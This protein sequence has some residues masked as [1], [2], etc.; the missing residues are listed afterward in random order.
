M[1]NVHKITG[2]VGGVEF[3]LWRMSGTEELGQSFQYEIEMLSETGTVAAKDMLGKPLVVTINAEGFDSRQFH[4]LVSRFERRGYRKPFYAYRATIRPW[5]W[6]L[7]HTADCRIFQTKSI[8][9]I[10]TDVF[11]TKNGFSDFRFSLNET[12]K[13]REYCVQYRESDFHFVSRLMEEEGIYYFFEH[14]DSKHTLV[15]ADGTAAHAGVC[16]SGTPVRFDTSG[17]S[18]GENEHL[19]NWTPA[20][21]LW[22]TGYTVR[23]Y[24]FEK[25]SANLEAKSQI[26]QQHS[27][28]SYEWYDYPN[29]YKEVADGTRYAKVWVE[30]FQSRY[31]L[32]AGAGSSQR[33]ATGCKFTLSEHPDDAENAEYL[34]V[35]TNVTIQSGEIAAFAGDMSNKFD[36]KLTAIKATKQYRVPRQ[37]KKP[38]IAGPQTAIV[39]GKSG[40]EIWTDKY[41]RVKVQ[42]P[43]DRVGKKDETSSC[44]LR[45]AQVWAGKNW[46]G[47]EIPRIGQEVLVQFMEGDPDRPIIVGRVYNAEQ[48]PPYTLPDN[49]TQSGMKTRSSKAGT[50]ENFNELRFED[51]KDAEEVYFHAEKNFNRVVENNDTLKVGFEK[52]DKGDQTL[53]I[54][55]NRT[56]KVGTSEAETGNETIVIWNNRSDT[57]G[58]AQ[59]SDGSLTTEIWKDETRTIKTGNQT[60]KIDQGNRDVTITTGNDSLKLAAGNLTIKMDAGSCTIEAATS[61]ELKVGGSSIKI[62]PAAITIKS[63]G[64]TVQGNATADVKSPNTTVSGDAALILKGGIVK[65]N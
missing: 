61:I 62:E 7:N 23:D 33:L 46:G 40:E 32:S 44:W 37:S 16:K 56:L 36:V 15:M 41:G 9:D 27:L 47:I 2:P 22:T 28:S 63:T 39:V 10:L 45:V 1:E 59:S 60:I 3:L 17:E 12:Y 6:F 50:A 24:D 18:F 58:N 26:S 42:F 53:E 30:G 13:Q 57:I 4:G 11:K 51:K 31:A 29:N 5:L 8:Q 20:E 34:I 65:I 49:A 25:P 48:M 55:N 38:L 52:K 54:F 19:T 21:E 14:T 43:W 35:A 64:V